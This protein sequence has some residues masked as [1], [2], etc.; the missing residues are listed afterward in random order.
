MSRDLKGRGAGLC[1]FAPS[2][3]MLF[4]RRTDGTWGIPG[5]H[6]QIGEDAIETALREFVEETAYAGRIWIDDVPIATVCIGERGFAPARRGRC[7]RPRFVYT[8]FSASVSEPFAP[9][10]DEEH[11]AFAWAQ[12]LSAPTPLHPGL[13]VAIDELFK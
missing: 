5:G 10:L 11:R 2:G 6:A 9:R 13:A 3:R 4:M 7:E 1:V 12:P 8:V